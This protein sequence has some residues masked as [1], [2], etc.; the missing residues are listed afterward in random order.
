MRHAC[1]QVADAQQVQPMIPSVAALRCGRAGM[2]EFQVALHAQVLKQ[3]CFLK[4]IAQRPQVHGLEN[5][6]CNV[7]PHL[8]G[9]ADV[10]LRLGFQPGQYAQTGGFPRARGA[11]QRRHAMCGQGHINVKRKA[12]AFQTG[13]QAQRGCRVGIGCN[14]HGVPRCWA[15]KRWL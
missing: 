6:L 13:L 7:L 8:C 4:H 2:A 11:K 5:A 9:H 10:A 14:G 12:R 15:C 1:Q 3:T